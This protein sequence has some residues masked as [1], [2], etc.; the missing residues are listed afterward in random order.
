MEK[1]LYY[2]LLG[3]QE[4]WKVSEIKLDVMNQKVDVWVEYNASSS[5]CSECQ[6]LCPIYD[7]V[8][9]RSWRHLDSCGFKT[10]IHAK[11]PRSKCGKHGILQI[12]IPWAQGHSRFTL[13]FQVLAISLLKECTV[14]GAAKILR[15]TWDQAWHIMKQAVDRGLLRKEK[16]K[17]SF[18][19][20]DEK[21]VMKGHS[22]FTIIYNLEKSTVEYIAE[23]RKTDSL[24]AYFD[25]I[26]EEQ[27][28]FIKAVSM[29]M[30]DP[31]IKATTEALGKD[32]IVI[33]RFH[34]MKH[35]NKAVDE[36]RKQE[37]KELYAQNDHT[38]KGSKY[39]WLYGEENIP[40][41]R[42]ADFE[43]LKT[44][45]LKV[46][47]AWAIKEMLRELWNS[48]NLKS[49]LHYIL[50]WFDWA[51]NCGLKPIKRAANTIADHID[52][53]LMYFKHKITNATSE[54][55]NS[56]I[57]KVKAMACGYRNKE[58]FK[59]AIY[60]HCGGLELYP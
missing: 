37:V 28:A 56:K 35:I 29:D 58:N 39:L 47:K 49:A 30:W 10:Y 8:N 1:N 27:K 22:Y 3:L 33:D 55:M 51:K 54:G 31:Y 7:H 17:S 48:V 57:Q 5:P 52:Q 44:K 9:E 2:H 6:T 11:I 16:E 34:V 53:I 41:N 59:T 13:M 14:S 4:P 20:V 42:K 60:F 18:L 50:K 36:V 38:L 23:D 12:K 43:I 21:S 26:S 24:K 32:K 40:Q 25:A 19:G 15:I 45:M 46:S